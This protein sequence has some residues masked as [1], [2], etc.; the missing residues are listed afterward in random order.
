[1]CYFHMLCNFRHLKR[2]VSHA[3]QALSWNLGLQLSFKNRPLHFSRILEL[4]S[5]LKILA[6][7]RARP[8][9]W[10][11]QSNGMVMVLQKHFDTLSQDFLAVLCE[12]QAPMFL[13]R[14]NFCQRLRNSWLNHSFL[15]NPLSPRLHRRPRRGALTQVTSCLSTPGVMG[16]KRNNANVAMSV[17]RK[18][19]HKESGWNLCGFEISEKI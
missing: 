17:R 7:W 13:W 6:G 15:H 1:M 16:K 18:G 10:G 19:C 3:P 11:Q 4:G 5:Q 9:V 14:T 12:P 8:T 2:N